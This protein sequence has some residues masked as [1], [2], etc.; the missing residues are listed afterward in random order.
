MKNTIKI[1]VVV[2]TYN[3]A[4]LL[5]KCLRSLVNQTLNKNLF[6]VIIID[7]K[8]TD[9]TI[10]VAQNFASKHINFRLFQEDKQGLS[11]ARNLGY[12]KARGKYVA[13]IDD[14]GKADKNWTKRIVEAFENILPHPSAVG[15]KIIPYYLSKK[16][17]WFL[18]IYE[19][20]TWGERKGFLE[21]PR[22]QFGFPGSNMAMQKSLLKKYGGFPL[23]YGMK[24]KKVWLGEEVVLFTKIFKE[25]PYFWY[26]SKIKI[27]HLVP[28]CKMT[29]KYRLKRAFLNGVCTTRIN[30]ERKNIFYLIKDVGYIVLS[31]IVLPFRVKWWKK[32][33]QRDL[34]KYAKSI[35]EILGKTMEILKITKI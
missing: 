32:Y 17:E 26:D 22:A 20:R 2:C 29:L 23:D 25:K 6:E 21:L 8:S 33:W 31:I 11:H 10:K 27:E 5:Q 7:N 1:S 34:L 3:R 9:S 12:K 35:A 13:Y 15:G 19:I 4:N 30:A 24:G 16:P 28:K 18:D 14:D